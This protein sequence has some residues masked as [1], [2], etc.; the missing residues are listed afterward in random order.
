[1]QVGFAACAKCLRGDH[2]STMAAAS[3]EKKASCDSREAAGWGHFPATVVPFAPAKVAI[4]LLPPL[5]AA[6]AMEAESQ[7][8]D[9]SYFAA[10]PE[11]VV[12]AGSF[13]AA[14]DFLGC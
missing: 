6:V 1:M 13:A 8:W 12:A 5:D 2:W 9:C 4:D 3:I 10:W 14:D 7:L 11:T